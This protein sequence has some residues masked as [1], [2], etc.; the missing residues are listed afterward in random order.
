VFYFY[1]EDYEGPDN[2]N[3]LKWIF[4]EKGEDGGIKLTTGDIPFENYRF[5]P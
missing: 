3:W 5:K 1:R 2:V 4:A